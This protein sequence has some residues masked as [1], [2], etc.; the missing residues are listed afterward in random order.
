MTNLPADEAVHVRAPGKINLFLRVG[1]V[2]NDGYHSV[3]SVY[4]AVSLF[5]DVHAWPDDEISVS[6]V[7]SPI[8]T[9]GLPTDD[10]NLA[11]RAAKL[12]AQTTGVSAGARIEITK[13]VPIAGGMGGGSADAAAT[14]I[15]C[16]AL[17]GTG[18]SRERLLALGSELGADVPFALLGG[19]AVGTGRGDALS[20]VLGKAQFHWVLAV[21]DGELSTPVV[22]DELDRLRSARAVPKQPTHTQFSADPVILTALRSGNAEQLAEGLLNDL[23]PAAIAL[24]PELAKL[25]ELGERSGALMGI[26]SG[27]GPTVAFLTTGAEA[28]LEL[29][30]LLSAAQVTAMHVHG[31][32]HGARVVQD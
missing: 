27:S 1:G 17:W 6:F 20:A 12:L 9:S 3:V 19:A 11:V 32:V 4:Q 5:E 21:S 24:A 18:L 25:V 14:L 15:A 28:A 2:E 23:Q 30:V 26:V 31:P 10:S 16:D 8:D 7:E 13:R 22:Y 29:Q